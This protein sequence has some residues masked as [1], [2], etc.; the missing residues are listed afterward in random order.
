MIYRY[1]KYSLRLIICKLVIV[2]FMLQRVFFVLLQ[3][4]YVYTKQHYFAG[5]II[6]L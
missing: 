1:M 3:I 2:Y 5:N 6:P 4:Y